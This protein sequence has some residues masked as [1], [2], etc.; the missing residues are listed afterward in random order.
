MYVKLVKRTN[1]KGV[2]N[3]RGGMEEVVPNEYRMF[4]ANDI[5]YKKIRIDNEEELPSGTMV[6]D[7][8]DMSPFEIFLIE[9]G[10]QDHKE[11]YVAPDC[12]MF[13]MNDEGKTID[14]IAC[15]QYLT[16]K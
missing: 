10:R 2:S 12:I 11:V 3:R 13:I 6:F 14:H 5:N 7:V 1:G 16:D 8:P 4:D 9:L 15:S